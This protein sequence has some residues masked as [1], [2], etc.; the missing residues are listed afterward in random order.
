MMPAMN[1]RQI[2]WL[3]GGC[4]L[5]AALVVGLVPV[6]KQG[7]SCGS[8][9]HKSNQAE[10]ADLTSTFAGVGDTFG[11]GSIE[12]SCDSTRSILKIPTFALAGIGIVLLCVGTSLNQTKVIGRV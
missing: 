4:L 6:H 8:A 2:L 10:I 7:V 11:D 12:E 9:L 5:G 3:I 1:A